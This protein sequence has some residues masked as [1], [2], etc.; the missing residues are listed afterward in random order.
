MEPRK[1]IRIGLKTPYVNISVCTM[2]R[3]D[4]CHD[5]VRSIVYIVV[6]CTYNAICIDSAK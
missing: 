3:V 2:M 5:V 1:N 6:Y 4:L